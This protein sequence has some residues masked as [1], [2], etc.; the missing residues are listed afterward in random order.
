MNFRG[1]WSVQHQSARFTSCFIERANVVVVQTA[2]QLAHSFAEPGVHRAGIL[3]SAGGRR[4]IPHRLV[5]DAEVH[6][7]ALQWRPLQ[8]DEP[9]LE[10]LFRRQADSAALSRATA[11]REA[12]LNLVAKGEQTD[13]SGRPQFAYAHPMFWAPFSLVGEGANR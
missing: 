9:A 3:V 1:Q 11:L 12:M 2:H 8:V 6:G 10:D 13:D 7:Q 5:D 4:V